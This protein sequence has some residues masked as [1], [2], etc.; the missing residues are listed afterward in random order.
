M[1]EIVFFVTS[2]I[3]SFILIFWFRYS[4]IEE[5]IVSDSTKSASNLAFNLL[6]NSK[7]SLILEVKNPQI[8][9]RA[10]IARR[11]FVVA[12][13]IYISSFCLFGYYVSKQL[14]VACP[15]GVHGK[16]CPTNPSQ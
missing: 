16:D 3:F 5:I 14:A 10:I 11:L 13:T 8:F 1:F 9:K 4:V 15:R 6:F 2:I 7:E 12:F